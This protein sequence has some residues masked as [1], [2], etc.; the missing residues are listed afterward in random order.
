MTSVGGWKSFME[1]YIKRNIGYSGIIRKESKIGLI[2]SKFVAKN[3]Q[4]VLQ[5]SSG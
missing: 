1:A 3:M 2:D 5:K 4:R